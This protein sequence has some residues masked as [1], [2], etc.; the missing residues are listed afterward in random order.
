MSSTYVCLDSDTGAVLAYYA[1]AF[2]GLS[3]ESASD[4]VKKGIPR[5]EIPVII[6]ARMAVCVSEQGKGLG[7][8]M[9]RD[10]L[11]RVDRVTETVGVRCLLIHVK[12]EAASQFYLRCAEFEQS[13]TDPMNLQLLI[14][15][16]RLITRLQ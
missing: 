4:R 13:P 16:L 6:L 9:V 10:A 3:H 15:D 12:D 2:G 1:L 8:A 7:Q 11:I 5:H 14:K